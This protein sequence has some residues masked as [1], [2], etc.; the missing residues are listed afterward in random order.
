V[1]RVFSLIIPKLFIILC[2][3]DVCFLMVVENTE[4]TFVACGDV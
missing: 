4:D 3:I 1:R 2:F